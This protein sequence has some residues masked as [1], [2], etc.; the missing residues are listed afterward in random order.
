[1]LAETKLLNFRNAIFSAENAYFEEQLDYRLSNKEIDALIRTIKIVATNKPIDYTGSDEKNV[2]KHSAI[3]KVLT[4]TIPIVIDSTYTFYHT[5]YT[6][7]FDDMWGEKDWT[8]MFVS[9]LLATGKGNCHSMDK[10]DKKKNYC[11]PI[12]FLFYI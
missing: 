7:D 2:V 5:P 12:N 1:M 3:Y 9:K 8:K 6:Y 11:C 4:D 10:K